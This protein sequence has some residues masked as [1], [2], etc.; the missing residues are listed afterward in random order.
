MD[1]HQAYIN[2]YNH[3]CELKLQAMCKH[4]DIDYAELLPKTI[5]GEV[6]PLGVWDYE[7]TYD[8][9]KTLG[10]KR[11]MVQEGNKLSITVSGV[12]K[13]TAVPY[14]LDQN[15]IEDCFNIFTEGLVIPAENTG[16]LTHYYI[17]NKY[18]GTVT[19]YNGVKYNYTMFSG[20]YLEGAEY[21]FDI[22]AE[23]I[24]FLKGVFYTK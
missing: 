19:D 23:Y 11:Y 2:E 18:T 15:T 16:K 17:D 7:G 20:V 5:K 12:N 8:R 9:F 4:Y 1:K 10:A 14:L 3:I 13:K 22:S 21:H 24:D 6:K